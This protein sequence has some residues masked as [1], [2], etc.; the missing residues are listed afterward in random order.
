MLRSF[1]ITRGGQF[2]SSPAPELKVLT[3]GVYIDYSMGRRN[4]AIF[5]GRHNL[6]DGR[7]TASSL[8]VAHIGLY[9]SN[10]KWRTLTGGKAAANGIHLDGISNRRPSAV[11]LY[12]VF[13]FAC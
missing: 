2:G 12:V 3:L 11:A 10:E 8:T 6:Q 9:R 1:K 4:L 13:A 7:E 5:E